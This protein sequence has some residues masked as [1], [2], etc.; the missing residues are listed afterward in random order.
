MNEQKRSPSEALN[1]D[2]YKDPSDWTEEDIDKLNLD[3]M[4][5]SVDGVH[6]ML[7]QNMGKP[8]FGFLL[9]HLAI[10]YNLAERVRKKG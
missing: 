5:E 7:R 1:I 6:D 2:P 3:F 10:G 9:G 4:G 8:A